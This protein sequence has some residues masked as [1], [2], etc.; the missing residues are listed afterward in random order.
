MFKPNVITESWLPE[1][2]NFNNYVRY[3]WSQFISD[4]PYIYILGNRKKAFCITMLSTKRV[5]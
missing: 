3:Q 1:S 4:L 5:T 2:I